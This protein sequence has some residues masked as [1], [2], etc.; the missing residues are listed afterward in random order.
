[1]S[2]GC[3]RLDGEKPIAEVEE[4][5]VVI[6]FTAKRRVDLPAEV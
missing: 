3:V 1:M 5:D 4:R 2:G 6:F